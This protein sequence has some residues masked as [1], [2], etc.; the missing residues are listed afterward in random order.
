M[1]TRQELFRLTSELGQNR[2]SSMRAYVFRCTPTTDIPGNGSFA[3]EAAVAGIDIQLPLYPRKLT[4]SS[5]RGMS[6]KCQTQTSRRFTRSPRR[7]EQGALVA[8]LIEVPYRPVGA[9]I[10]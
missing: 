9:A 10:A 6:E 8:S 4:Q 1:S 2:K 5:K 3:P 7:R